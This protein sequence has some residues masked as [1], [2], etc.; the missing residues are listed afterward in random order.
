[1]P[2][3]LKKS[4]THNT[5]RVV[6]G[7]LRHRRFNDVEGETTRSTK[8]RVKEAI[9]NRLQ[10]Q[11]NFN[12]VL[13]LYAGSGS[14]AIEA[15]SRGASNVVAI[16]LDKPAFDILQENCNALEARINTRLMHALTYLE[17]VDSSYD[18]IIVDPPYDADLYEK[19]LT[20]IHQNKRLNPHG[21][22]VVLHEHP[23][24]EF[25][26]FKCLK[27]QRYGRTQ[28]TYFEER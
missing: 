19:T 24:P 22:V 5:L 11:K 6:A 16:E 7:R 10:H 13:D 9:F 25:K 2:K 1:M 23:L 21:N 27:N 26:A 3:Q 17:T 15:Y 12:S 20:L 4:P 18:V 8:D 14:L 28:V